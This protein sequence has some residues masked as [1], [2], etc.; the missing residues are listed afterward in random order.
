MKGNTILLSVL[1]LIFSCQ[2]TEVEDPNFIGRDKE[3][4][5]SAKEGESKTLLKEI[6][7]KQTEFLSFKSEFSMQIQTFVPKK[8]NVS[9]D[10]KLYFS[11]ESKQIKIQLMDSF[12]GMVFTELIADPNQIQIKPTSTKDIQ[13]LPM[14][15]ILIQDPNTG[16]KFAI[17]FPVIYE[18]LTG[19]YVSEIQSPKA[20]F[21]TSDSRIALSKADGEYEYFFRAGHLDRL[22]LASAKR[23]L[24]AIALVKTKPEQIHPPK[25]IITKVIS[26]DTEKENVLIQI[27]LKKSQITEVPSNVFRF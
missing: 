2:S 13:T 9:L 14:G 6:L 12:F 26:L 11:K 19:A 15:D 22:E 20:K 18:Y 5:I 23:G 24:K 4:Y 17:P 27:K 8:D 7:E 10:G 25:E 1:F 16:K 3:K 21:N